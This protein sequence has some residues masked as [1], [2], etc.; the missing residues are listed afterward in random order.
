MSTTK[1]VQRVRV[2]V[3][4]RHTASMVGAQRMYRSPKDLRGGPVDGWNAEHGVSLRRIG[5]LMPVDRRRDV[6]GTEAVGQRH[7]GAAGV[8]EGR[9]S[10]DTS[11]S[12]TPS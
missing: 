8:H 12:S 6:G 11:G 10:D 7:S 3:G 5:L 1:P 9:G 2:M 4:D